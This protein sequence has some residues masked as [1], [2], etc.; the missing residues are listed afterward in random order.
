MTDKPTQRDPA[1]WQA[2]LSPRGEQ[3]AYRACRRQCRQAFDRQRRLIRRVFELKR[4]KVV[5]CLG[6]GVLNDIPYRTFVRAGVTIHLVDW[7][8]GAVEDGIAMSIITADEDA[9]PRCAYCDLSE[10]QARTYCAHF[11]GPKRPQARVCRNFVPGPGDPPTCL[12]FEKSDRPLVH[13]EDVT[14][15]YASAFGERVDEAL[16]GARS[17]KQALARAADL[18]RR[19][20]RHGSSLSI[21]DASV[22]LV[23]SS[24]LVSQFEHEPY[25]YFSRQTARRL[26]WP[27]ADEARRLRPAMER[28]R[29]TLFAAQIERH[30]DEILRILAPGGLCFMSIEMFHRDPDHEHWF[31]VREMH[32]ALAHLSERF[33]FNF[34]VIGEADCLTRFQTDR[35]P[36]LVF[37]FVLEAGGRDSELSPP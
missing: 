28:L 7:M 35:S 22:D 2:Y 3:I 24:M 9:S 27:D 21:A 32:A 1:P 26:G 8:P 5:C 36:S 15:G 34:D 25:R 13:R 33:R 20:Q 29:S 4:P 18:A 30:C 16:A 19:V 14:G 12:K 23:T 17:W 10:D 11:A 6:A 31:A 37:S